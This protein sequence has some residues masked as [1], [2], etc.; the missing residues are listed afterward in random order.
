MNLSINS[1]NPHGNVMF[2]LE[3]LS[4]LKKVKVLMLLFFVAGCSNQEDAAS[5]QNTNSVSDKQK[6]EQ[7]ESAESYYEHSHQHDH[8]DGDTEDHDHDH[9][10]SNHV[11]GEGHDHATEEKPIKHLEI[12]KVTNLGDAKRIFK[13]ESALIKEIENFD[14]ADLNQ[15]HFITYRLEQS[16][17]YFADNLSGDEKKLIDEMAVVV[18]EIHL[19]SERNRQPETQ[20]HVIDYLEMADK[21]SQSINQ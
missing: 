1:R 21:F 6:V 7:V 3:S 11:S 12:P 9:S 15:L 14:E 18:E 2:N 13:E 4:L 16:V 20:A 8:D 10:Q 19:N 5:N 17:F